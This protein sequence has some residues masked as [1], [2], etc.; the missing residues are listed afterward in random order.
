M[1]ICWASR[2][3][4][5]SASSRT[6]ALWVRSGSRNSDLGQDARFH[7]GRV[8][9]CIGPG[10]RLDDFQCDSRSLADVARERKDIHI[11]T[12]FTLAFQ[13]LAFIAVLAFV[14]VLIRTMSR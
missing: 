12:D 6:T 7:A 5:T 8:R 1:G 2:K 13:V 14:F 3:D 10:V 9:C 11:M 4:G